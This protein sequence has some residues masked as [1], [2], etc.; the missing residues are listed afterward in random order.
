MHTCKIFTIFFLFFFGHKKSSFEPAAL[1]QYNRIKRKPETLK[2]YVC[3]IQMHHIYLARQNSNREV[4][5]FSSIGVVVV[6]VFLRFGLFLHSLP[7]FSL[8]P[9]I[10]LKSNTLRLKY[11][12]HFYNL[13]NHSTCRRY[14]FTNLPNKPHH[15]NML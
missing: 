1:F 8:T 15:Q 10:S 3:T 9:A 13:P 14:H 11:T 7:A 4:Q 12:A 2:W 5:P 6:V